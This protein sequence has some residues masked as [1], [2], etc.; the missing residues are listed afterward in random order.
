[1]TDS[2]RLLPI[3]HS[4]LRYWSTSLYEIDRFVLRVFGVLSEAVADDADITVSDRDVDY[5]ISSSSEKLSVI[6]LIVYINQT[7]S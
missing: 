4:P 3:I 1:M 7:V 2:L 5:A 6:K